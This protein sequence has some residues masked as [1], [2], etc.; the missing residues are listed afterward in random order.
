[1][2]LNIDGRINLLF[3]FFWGLIA[4]LWVQNIYP[5]LS[6]KIEG[7]PM[8]YGKQLTW[9][10]VVF[11][12][13]DMLLSSSALIRG[14]QRSKGIEST[15][16]ISSFLDEHYPDDYLMQRYQNMFAQKI[17]AW[18]IAKSLFYLE[19]AYKRCHYFFH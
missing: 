15:S 17:K 7:I 5:F 11:L 14:Y 19:Y 3:C 6:K 18:F 9:I 8:R 10:L 2:A 13:F 12:I 16:A 1:M 4:V